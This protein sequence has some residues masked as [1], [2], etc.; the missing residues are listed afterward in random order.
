MA[1][2]RPA[3]NQVPRPAPDLMPPQTPAA[4]PGLRS[5]HDNGGLNSAPQRVRS[6]ARQAIQTHNGDDDE[7]INVMIMVMEYDGDDRW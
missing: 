7:L 5:A 2:S 1:G 4:I 6:V 3:G